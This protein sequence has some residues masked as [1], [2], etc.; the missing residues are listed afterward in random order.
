MKRRKCRKIISSIAAIISVIVVLLFYANYLNNSF[1]KQTKS[2]L[3]EMANQYTTTIEREI[4]FQQT[5]L[6]EVANRIEEVDNYLT[7]Q[8]SVRQ[9]MLDVSQRFD[10]K[11][12][13]VADLNGDCYTSDNMVFNIKGKQYFED[14]L[15]GKDSISDRFL[16]VTNQEEII[17]VFSSPLYTNNV[18]SGVL[19]GTYDANVLVS[20]LSDSIIN[21]GF[22]SYILTKDGTLL[23][24]TSNSAK[25]I[26][27]TMC[28]YLLE[29]DS[30]NSKVVDKIEKALLEK[31]TNDLFEVYINGE[32]HFL[33]IT[34][35]DTHEWFLITCIPSQ[36][37]SNTRN[38][39]ML[40]TY[41]IIFLI[42]FIIVGLNFYISLM[43]RKKNNEL[44]RLV[45]QDDLTK[46]LSYYE[47]L[48]K[49]NE[50]V[51]SGDKTNYA[52]VVM[53]IVNFKLI[54]EMYGYDVGNQVLVNV[55]K[56]LHEKINKKELL[57]R[58]FAD[59]YVMLLE[60]KN[61]QEL[62]NRL[63]DMQFLLNEEGIIDNKEYII[64]SKFGSYVVDRSTTSVP[65]MINSAIIAYSKHKEE[66]I[67]IF[68][69]EIK[70]NILKTK[71]LEDDM[72]RA[73]LNNEYIVYLQPKVSTNSGKIVGAESL[74]RWKKPDGTIILP[75]EF[76]PLAEQNGFV[77]K[78]DLCV[79]TR[80]CILQKEWLQKYGYIVPISVNISRD[81]LSNPNYPRQLNEIREYYDL[82]IDAIE[83]EITETA[84]FKEK[85]YFISNLNN[86]KK[87]GFK[88]LM[89]DFGT[90]YSSI[91]MLKEFKIDQVKLDR[92]FVQSYKEE[93]GSVILP[94]LIKLAKSLGMPVTAEG[95]E[96]KEEFE[97]LKKLDCDN[98]QGYYFFKPMLEIDF[99]SQ[100][101]SKKSPKK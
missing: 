47:F 50:L 15:K 26:E 9:I 31:N 95:V 42:L 28:Q 70:T 39:M 35:L 13:G 40:I 57:S 16:D 29:Q 54:N 69:N 44:N 84:L 17:I 18:V 45:I 49:V 12:I 41:S 63:R 100:L 30:R 22:L 24:Q 85:D 51:N 97:F 81:N 92:S 7:N 6:A 82:P 52:I 72:E 10:F 98:I 58:M 34:C 87:Y 64:K 86:L 11:R 93:K 94:L 5:I 78:L 74:I 32:K 25:S 66:S 60:Y 62:V 21:S 90:G 80:T 20:K 2:S 43:L 67:S 56:S 4:Y 96:T 37:Y 89:D 91:R 65:R 79:F 76:I 33:K 53:N 36:I 55:Y 68:N 1:T 99:E 3:N 71:Y 61:D 27:M 73:L 59:N 8:S 14:S 48:N 19:F 38:Q 23:A 77:S 75:N 101:Y 46:G 83:I 88:I